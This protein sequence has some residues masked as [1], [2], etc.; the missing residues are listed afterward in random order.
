MRDDAGRLIDAL[1]AMP[2]EMRTALALQVTAE[3]L[4]FTA[5]EMAQTDDARQVA[6]LIMLSADLERA[7]GLTND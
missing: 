7:A 4:E 3:F 5:Y 1:N 2:A 6:R